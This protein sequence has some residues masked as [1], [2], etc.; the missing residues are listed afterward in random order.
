MA[1]FLITAAVGLG[2]NALVPLF[3]GGKTSYQTVE[4]GK[5]ENFQRP[6]SRYGE[7]IPQVWGK[8]R[9]PGILIWASFPPREEVSE[10]VNRVS[11]SK[12]SPGSVTTNRNYSYF[13]NCAFLLSQAITEDIP[14]IWFNGELL[15]ENN[16]INPRISGVIVRKY[17]GYGTIND[18]PDP[19]LESFGNQ[20]PYR[21]R[22]YVV[23]ENLPLEAFGNRYP[24]I[25]AEVTNGQPRL[26]DIVGD[27]LQDHGYEPEEYDVSE[28]NQIQVPG[29]KIDREMSAK[30]KLGIL[31]QA[32][33]FEMVDSGDKLKFVTQFRPSSSGTIPLT[34]LATHEDG[35]ERPENFQ[36]TTIPE[37][38]L[39]TQIEVG[40]ADRFNNYQDGLQRS[41]LYSFTN[42]IN[43]QRVELPISLTES[44]AKTIANKQLLLSWVRRKKYQFTLPP[45]Y[46]YLEPAD[47]IEV[48]FH[49]DNAKVQVSR[50]NAGANDVLE[51]E[52]IGY[53]STIYGFQFTVGSTTPPPAQDWTPSDTTLRVLELPKVFDSDPDCLYIFADGDTDWRNASLYV[54]RNGGA[55]Y[56]FASGIVTR[57]LFG[58]VLNTLANGTTPD[59]V[60]QINLQIPF[61][62]VLDTVLDADLDA[63]KNTV[64]VGDEILQFKTSALTGTSGTDRLYT[65][66][67][68]RRALRG[69]VGNT[70]TSGEDF[71]DLSGYLTRFPIYPADIGKTL[72]F[73]AITA[74]QVLDDVL[75]VTITVTGQASQPTTLKIDDFSPSLANIGDTVTVYGAKFTGATVLSIN[76][77]NVNSLTII[78][79]TEITGEIA[80]GTTSG[81]VSVTSPAGT[82][83]SLTDLTITT[84]GQPEKLTAN[85][86]YYVRTDGDD[87]NDGLANTAGGAFLTPAKAAS[88]ASS[89]D[90]NGFNIYIQF[91]AGTYTGAI[92]LFD[93][94][95]PGEIILQGDPLDPSAV[96]L[97]NTVADTTTI[98]IVNETR[99]WIRDLTLN[100]AGT[101]YGFCLMGT[102]LGGCFID[103]V[104]FGNAPVGHILSDTNGFIG[105]ADIDN[106]I[107][108]IGYTIFGNASCHVLLT[109]G[110]V[111]RPNGCTITLSGVRAFSTAYLCAETGGIADIP[112][113]TYIGTATG[114]KYQF[115]SNVSVRIDNNDLSLLPGDLVGTGEEF[116][117][118][119]TDAGEI[120][121]ELIRFLI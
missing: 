60:N 111:Y 7:Y 29:F 57:S 46:S 11:G 113:V 100:N 109:A 120:D 49:G 79:D 103:N 95:G 98:R 22:C 2:T 83:T 72:Y 30:E 50:V 1:N 92:D 42:Y 97:N 37:T 41:P 84:F 58:D 12:G 80:T 9:V 112:G 117:F 99:Y 118:P 18:N 78:S 51:I 31:Q 82:A 26:S 108:G 64:L 93:H 81:K 55:S 65:L 74:G 36:E 4:T 39:P 102:N 107:S 47:V 86:T 53:Q 110:G 119:V 121:I 105:V 63:G 44:E 67:N 104:R 71:Y 54:S 15:Y 85:R 35:Q 34:Y 87:A 38:Q 88:V 28:L 115:G 33:F 94:D 77:V 19:L 101:G 21:K 73:K 40:F 10:S 45:S 90:K 23:F 32:Y 13:G 20:Q 43:T 8:V 91:A 62:G 66:S 3:A 106:L 24:Q 61:H 89:V 14:K 16:N 5:E 114:K 25:S 116:G 48:P 69:T 6:S 56:E 70:H 59:T 76:G 68:L 17:Q 75:P 52:A 96:T 27:I